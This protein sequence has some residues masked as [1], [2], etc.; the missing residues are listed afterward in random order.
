MKSDTPHYRAGLVGCGRMSR[1][2]IPALMATPGLE[3]VAL[4]D[5][6]QPAVRERGEQFG[7]APT[8]QYADYREML[9]QE[10][11]DIVTIST[12]APQHA[13]ATLACA[14]AGVRGVLCEKPIALSLA[15][16]DA[17]VAACD[18]TGMRLG[19]NHQTRVSPA[20]YRAEEMIHSGAIG[21]L[22]GVRIVD[23]GGRPAGNSLMEMG[24]HLFDHTRLYAGDPIWVAAHL[25]DAQ[26]DG[27]R[28]TSTV[29]DIMYSQT[30]WPADRDC[31]LVLGSRA[32]TVFGFDSASLHN[33]LEATFVSYNQ[34][35][36]DKSWPDQLELIGLD[37]VLA[38]RTGDLFLHRGAWGAPVHFEPVL[39]GP[40]AQVAEPPLPTGLSP[41][42]VTGFL[43]SFVTMLTELRAAIEEERPHRSD[44][45]DGR[46][47]LDMIMGVYESHRQNGARITLPLSQREHPLERWLKDEGQPLPHHPEA[48]RSRGIPA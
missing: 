44:V 18:R 35:G 13:P 2:H 26:A 17:M 7:V 41:K 43:G 36:G 25:T 39:T 14:E 22:V 30:A 27:R 42:H 5:P 11:L 31:G 3:L 48:T 12:Q 16:A 15:E 23:K 33:G 8:H 38:Y 1:H 37:G 21:E 4:S 46:W 40:A 32:T 29:N 9:H 24:T 10:A 20:T 19:I 45:R 28:H 34:P 47:A 6:Y